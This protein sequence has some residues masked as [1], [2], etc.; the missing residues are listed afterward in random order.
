MR[1]SGDVVTMIGGG[2]FKMEDKNW[3]TK[4]VGGNLFA[5]NC[6]DKDATISPRNF[7]PADVQ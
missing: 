2:N 5:V 7:D 1:I 3:F 4:L 6:Q